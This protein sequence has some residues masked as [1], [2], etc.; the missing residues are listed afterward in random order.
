MLGCAAVLLLGLAGPATAQPVVDGDL[1][2]WDNG[3]FTPQADVLDEP[4]DV[5]ELCRSG[6]DFTRCL[7]FYDI[8]TDKL[9]FGI[10][11]MDVREGE[12]GDPMGRPGA[13]VPGDADGDGNPSAATEICVVLADQ[14]CVGPDEQYLVRIDTDADGLFDEMVDVH[15]R[16]RSNVLSITNGFGVPIAGATGDIVLGF[17]GQEAGPSCDA[18]GNPLTEDIEIVIDDWSTLDDV[19]FCFQ[20]LLSAGSLQ[21]K[22]DEDG[23]DDTAIV[24]ID[25]TPDIMVTKRARNVTQQGPFRDGEIAARPGEEVEFE[26]EVCNTSD[27]PL[28][29]FVTTT[30]TDLL[31]PELIDVVL[32]PLCQSV[33]GQTAAGTGTSIQ[34]DLGA[35]AV[36]DCIT[37]TYTARVDPKIQGQV[38]LTNTASALGTTA[39]KPGC[40]NNEAT[41]FDS[42]RIAVVDLVCTK[43]VSTD[44]GMTYSEMEDGVP[45]QTVLFRVTVTNDSAV[46]LDSV[47]MVDALPD[48]YDMV[49]A[50]SDTCSAD[51]NTITCSVAPFLSG[52]TVVF[53]YQARLIGSN[54][55]ENV[56]NTANIIGRLGE[57]E[58]VT[59][60]SATVDVLA[61]AVACVKEVSLDGKDFSG[62]ISAVSC[63]EVF[64]RVTIMN[65][66]EAD[67]FDVT[68]TDVLPP[69]YSMPMTT[70][71]DCEV[72]EVE[73]TVSCLLTDPIPVGG[74][75]VIEYKADFIGTV[76][77]EVITNTAFIEATPGIGEKPEA[78]GDPVTTDCSADVTTLVASIV[79]QKDVSLVNGDFQPSIDAVPGQEVFFRVVV[80]NTGSAPFFSTLI[81]DPLPS[82]CFVDAEIVSGSGC[83]VSDEE[84]V[85]CDVRAVGPGQ[86]RTVVYKA[87]ILDIAENRLC[88]NTATVTGVPGQSMNEGCPAE[89]TCTAEVDVLNVEIL[90]DKNVSLDN[91]V[92]ENEIAAQPGDTVFFEVLVSIPAG[93]EACFINVQ[94]EDLLGPEFENV[95][96]VEGM[97]CSANGNL[98]RCDDLLPVPFC[99]EDPPLRVVYK[100]DLVDGPL[101][102]TVTNTAMVTGTPGIPGV[103]QGGTPEST[104]CTGII[105]VLDLEIECRKVASPSP[106]V[107]GQT[108]TFEVEIENTSKSDATFESVE[109]ADTLSEGFTNIVVLLPETGCDVDQEKRTI[110]CPDLGP[111]G[112]GEIFTVRY[113]AEVDLPDPAPDS[114]GNTA[115]VIGR[116]G[117]IE[118]MDECPVIIPLLDPCIECVKDA[119]LRPDN[120][121][122][123]SPISAIPGQRVFFRVTITNCGT[124]P[125]FR[126][127]LE[128]MLPPAFENIEIE[129]GACI[130]VGSNTV[131]CDDLGSLAPGASTV[132]RFS[133]ELRED[134]PPGMLQNVATV[135]GFPGMDG[136]EGESVTENC[137]LDINVLEIDFICTKLVSLDGTNFAETVEAVPGQTI[138]F[139][140]LV[141]NPGDVPVSLTLTDDLGSIYRDAVTEDPAICDFMPGNV[142]VCT[143]DLDPDASRTLNYRADIRPGTDPGTFTNTVDLAVETGPPENPGAEVERENAC[144]ANVVVLD[145]KILCEKGISLDGTN[146]FPSLVVQPEEHVFFRVFVENA[147]TADLRDVRLSDFVDPACFTNLVVTEPVPE[148]ERDGNRI[149]CVLGDL[150]AGESIEV[151]Y[152]ADV[153]TDPTQEECVNRVQITARTGR[154]SNEGVEVDTEC[155][156]VAS[157][158]VVRIPTLDE[159]GLLVLVL[160]L[161][162]TLLLYRRRIG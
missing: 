44:G 46:D 121:G 39:G 58:I 45:G 57:T 114:L 151:F 141:E 105:R 152:E 97:V 145:P 28:E 71:T 67:L 87:T 88:T 94:V 1:T 35:L 66:G 18:D 153:V 30:V 23:L 146:F 147:G 51:G 140:V 20:A 17:A 120:T 34:C 43:E 37:V 32:D 150:A 133:G 25:L 16:Y 82:D 81:E 107:D 143:F 6:F 102:E 117:S 41:D 101:P 76:D 116:L 55:G 148:C 15:V 162:A 24:N 85:S 154:E 95:M 75:A 112:Q 93:G 118:Q 104:D 54:P 40:G 134:Q 100:A 19:P 13:G 90:C 60:C 126:V 79:C 10:D 12:M 36:G 78:Q 109:F 137:P 142:L 65:A 33:L 156:A 106:V 4:N 89:N 131:R 49:M 160:V 80:E 31:P 130:E 27:N 99:P 74:E 135:T 77:Q 73:N 128:D 53:E 2:E 125:F 9:Y 129:E 8:D 158:V 149:D 29:D 63:Q 98:I 47:E 56:I 159:V 111:L 61:P 72:D 52:E 38:V 161:G 132:V 64:F 110:S 123:E 86:R 70:N 11:L 91:K 50:I 14:F 108:V 103:E 7:I 113:T 84:V 22:A 136:N 139:R 124:A 5:H 155:V 83:S 48:E 96:L 3:N 68:L 26:V 92:F 69:E 138:F 144:Q 127:S 21:D 42:V 59:F 119:T 157:T 115:K 122:Y 62:P